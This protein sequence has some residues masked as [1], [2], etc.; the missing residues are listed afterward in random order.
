M[1]SQRRRKLGQT[2]DERI[3]TSSTKGDSIILSLEGYE[4]TAKKEVE[5]VEE[6]EEVSNW[7][8]DAIDVI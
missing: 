7:R 2:L 3:S 6:E 1:E 8:S 5:E 4:S